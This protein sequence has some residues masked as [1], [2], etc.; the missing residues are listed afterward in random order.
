MFVAPRRRSGSELEP[1]GG[2]RDPLG[3]RGLLGTDLTG[4]AGTSPERLLSGLGLGGLA[5]G[6]GSRSAGR[7]PGSGGSSG[8]RQRP[9]RVSEMSGGAEV[10]RR[11]HRERRG[12]LLQELLN[13]CIGA[14]A[15]FL[16]A[17]GVL[18]T[19]GASLELAGAIGGIVAVCYGYLF[20][21]DVVA[22]LGRIRERS[23]RDATRW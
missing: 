6:R 4:L 23:E 1:G 10:V 14:G 21:R 15:S 8:G 3:L 5:G 12:E 13:V 7:G 20:G 17:G 19:S 22:D 18:L 11:R 9:D 2:S 16:T